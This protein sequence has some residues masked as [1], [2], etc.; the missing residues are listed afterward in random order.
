MIV[1]IELDSFDLRVAVR[2]MREAI[3]REALSQTGYNV[4]R[5]AHLLGIT[6]RG[7]QLCMKELG[8]REGHA[9]SMDGHT[10]FVAAAGSALGGCIKA[11]RYADD[12]E[13]T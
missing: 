9:L 11:A 8:L 6:R 2:R 12:E 1:T 10:T 4:A 7:L 3:V 13:P 5:A